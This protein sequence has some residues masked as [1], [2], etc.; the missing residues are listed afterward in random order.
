L[1]VDIPTTAVNATLHLMDSCASD[2][3]C[4]TAY[5]DLQNVLFEIVEAYNEHPMPVSLVNPLDGASYEALLTGDMIFGNLVFF[6][7]QTPI[8]PMLPKAVNDVANGDY[9]LMIQLSNRKLAAY[10]AISRG[11]SFSVLCTDDLIDRTPEDYLELRATLPS[12]LAGRTDPEDILQYGAF[13][14]CHNWPVEEADPAVKNPVASD[15]PTLILGGEFDPVTPP[16]YGRMVAEHL[17]N[18]YFYEFPSIG[19][20]VAVANSCARQMTADFLTDPHTPPNSSCI[21]TLAIEFVLPL[22]LEKIN[23]I[24]V[25]IQEFGIRALIP[26]GWTQVKPE[27]YISPDSTIELVIKEDT[28]NNREEFIQNWGASEP[29]SE[30]EGNDLTWTLYESNLPDYNIAGY[31]AT[32][33]SKDG[34]YMV[35]IVTTPDQQKLVFD[36]VFNPILEAFQYE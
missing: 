20:S 16:E 7:Y 19:H 27:Y 14:I 13:A 35:L 22:D 8:I 3:A 9:D 31:I 28:E 1:L 2:Q 21:K 32:A 18:S 15:I 36:S 6:L 10:D 33:P 29:I 23:L 11:M 17:N 12:A 25:S 4:N 5:P 30:L 26:D 34:F 24:P